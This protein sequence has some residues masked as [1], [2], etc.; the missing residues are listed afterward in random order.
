VYAKVDEIKPHYHIIVAKGRPRWMC[1]EN[2]WRVILW[3]RIIWIFA[4]E[5][6]MYS[7]TNRTWVPFGILWG[8]LRYQFRNR[9][10]FSTGLLFEWNWK[11]SICR[12]IPL[13][14]YRTIQFWCWIDETNYWIHHSYDF[15]NQGMSLFVS[16]RRTP[17]FNQI[18][19]TKADISINMGSVH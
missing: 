6:P 11:C 12:Y 4:Y 3:V 18:R 19:Q 1:K 13:P 17:C 7:V 2:I 16:I 14:L 9:D 5:H 10:K 15:L 8:R